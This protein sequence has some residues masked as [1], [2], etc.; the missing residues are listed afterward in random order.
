MTSNRAI[1]PVKLFIGTLGLEDVRQDERL[2][3][4]LTSE[5]G[6]SDHRLILIPTDGTIHRVL[7]SFGRLI[8]SESLTQIRGQLQSFERE[9]STKFDVG[10]V[11]NR[12]VVMGEAAGTGALEEVIHF[13]YGGVQFLSESLRGYLSGISQEFFLSMRRTYRAQLRSMCLLR[14]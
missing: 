10:Y 12:R 13:K 14:R 2:E 7:L 8:E 5:F 3:E 11:D 9:F 1:N 4:R 6:P